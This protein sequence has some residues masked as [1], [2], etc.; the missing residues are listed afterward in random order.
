MDDFEILLPLAAARIQ[1]CLQCCSNA[2]ARAEA[3]AAVPCTAGY[4][5]DKFEYPAE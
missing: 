3:R 4:E 1:H 2:E 5:Y